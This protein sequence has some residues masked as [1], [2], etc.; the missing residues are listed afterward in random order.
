MIKYWLYS[1]CYT[2]YPCRLCILYV[3]ICTSES[4]NPILS[5]HSSFALLVTT[6]LFSIVWICFFLLIFTSLLYFLDSTYKWHH[7]VF[8]FLYP[9][10]FTRD[11]TYIPCP[12]KQILYH[13]TIRKISGFFLLFHNFRD[14]RLSPI[15]CYIFISIYYF[16]CFLFQMLIFSLLNNYR[17]FKLFLNHSFHCNKHF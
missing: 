13:W 3:V 1:L 10:Y 16:S 6:S 4:P 12:G 5:L 9:T 11:Q 15:S 14:F 17:N 8:V 2:I 7:T